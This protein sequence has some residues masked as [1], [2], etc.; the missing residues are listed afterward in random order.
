MTDQGYDRPELLA[1][2][3]WLAEHLDDPNVRVV[4]C[5]EFDP[6]LRAHIKN[7]VGIRVHHYIKHPDYPSAQR[8]Y[9]LVAE[10]DVMKA[11]MEE[12]GIGD[13]TLVVAYDNSGS[14]YSTRFWWVLNYYGHTNVKV[15]NGG[16]RKWFDE[17]RPVS[18][19]RPPDAGDVTFSPQADES[20]VCSLEYGVGQVGN[21]D[22]VFLDVRSNGE[23]DGSND[24]GNA[25]AGRVPGAV[26]LEWLNL[27]TA[28][29]HRLFKPAS[30][31]KPM[32]E[33]LGVTPDKNV[34]TY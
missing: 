21:P 23:W 8:D 25:H 20:L 26:H 32:L 33:A 3:E 11:L 27:I 24:R 5:D 1:T 10:P 15:L 2:T 12:M 28:D 7:A 13:D 4:D 30:E 18:I 14:L 34:I 19:D 16:W 31:L 6:Y 9:P 17:G 22:T 29:R